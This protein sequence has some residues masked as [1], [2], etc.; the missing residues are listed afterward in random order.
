MKQLMRIA[1]LIAG[2]AL[3]ASG[4]ARADDNLAEGIDYIRLAA[5]QPTSDASKIEVVELFWYGCPHCYQLE[6]MLEKWAG[7]LPDDVALVRI[8]AVLNP[9]WDVLA[10]AYYTAEMLGVVEQIHAPLFKA[11]HEKKQKL[12]D[13][14]ALAE[15]FV[16][17][18]VDEKQ[19]RETYKSFGVVSKV[20]RA[21]QMTQRYGI[22]GVPA[23]VIDGKYRTSASEAGSHADMLKV[24][25]ALIARERQAR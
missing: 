1:M 22:R 7:A 18:G 20:N 6:P 4:A 23:L 5:P 10:R 3:V 14:D 12:D 15:F 11:I 16:A 13:E 17:Q 19:F 9:R 2:I 24:T 25:D 21:R 8:P